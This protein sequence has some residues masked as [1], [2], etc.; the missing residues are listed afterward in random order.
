MSVYKA[1]QQIIETTMYLVPAA[2]SIS[3]RS[4]KVHIPKQPYYDF[5]FLEIVLRSI[6]IH[7]QKTKGNIDVATQ[8]KKQRAE[9]VK[10]KR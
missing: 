7:Y 3:R 10:R 9:E 5:F 2:I 1:L 4:I 8:K 6:I